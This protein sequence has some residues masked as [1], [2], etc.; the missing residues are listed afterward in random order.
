MISERKAKLKVL[1][2]NGKL[3]LNNNTSEDGAKL[4]HARP[5][6]DLLLLEHFKDAK[7]INEEDIREEVDTFLFAVSVIVFFIAGGKQLLSL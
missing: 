6:L 7:N 1:V 2:D 4:K 5:L 3:T